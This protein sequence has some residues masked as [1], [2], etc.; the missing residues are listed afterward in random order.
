MVC[1][2]RDVK[3]DLRANPDDFSQFVHEMSIK[4][5]VGTID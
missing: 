2:N 4:G 5:S 1:K 3:V